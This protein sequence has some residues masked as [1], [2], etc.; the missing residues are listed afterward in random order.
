[1]PGRDDYDEACRAASIADVALRSIA[2]CYEDA[3]K[4]LKRR[5]LRLGGVFVLPC[6]AGLADSK[7]LL[8]HRAVLLSRERAARVRTSRCFLTARAL[9]Q[10][11]LRAHRSGPK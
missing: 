2:Q 7:W 10:S 3:A 5:V 1:M 6:R 9:L 11:R 4:S 8:Q